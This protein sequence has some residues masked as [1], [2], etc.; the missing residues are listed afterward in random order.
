MTISATRCLILISKPETWAGAVA[1]DLLC[2]GTVLRPDAV[3]SF[4]PQRGAMTPVPPS[5]SSPFYRWGNA[6]T[7][8]RRAGTRQHGWP[9]RHGGVLPRL[10]PRKAKPP[11]ASPP[12]GDLPLWGRPRP[13]PKHGEGRP[14]PAT[15]G[16]GSVTLCRGLPSPRV[17]SPFLSLL[18]SRN[19]HL[20][21]RLLSVCFWRPPPARA[22]Q[23][24][25]RALK[26]RSGPPPA[27]LAKAEMC[28]RD[29]EEAP[30]L[31][32]GAERTQGRAA[33]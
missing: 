32:A 17:S 12:R 16:R 18:L 5:R 1:E 10:P 13:L 15:L 23:G 27:V 26:T 9:R 3:D 19:G 31:R 14:T 24:R 28:F 21:P 6:G 4:S 2:A 25:S 22:S 7:S 20:V 33:N 8:G 11:A 30:G 29:V